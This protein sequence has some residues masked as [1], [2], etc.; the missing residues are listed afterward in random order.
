MGKYLTVLVTLCLLAFTNGSFK[1]EQ[2]RYSRVRTAYAEKEANMKN[3]LLANAIQLEQLEVYLRVFKAEQELELWAKNKGEQSYKFLK[4]YQV[5]QTSGSLGP[6]RKEGDLQI[7]E[8]F[9]HIDGFNPSSHYYLSMRL[10]YPNKSDQILG[11]KPRLGNNIFIHGDC[12]TIG[13][14]PITDEYIKELY[15]FCI[16]AKDKGQLKIPVSIYPCRLNK[17]NFA[18]LQK[19]YGEDEDKLNLWTDLKVSYQHFTQTKQLPTIT[20]LAN[21][22]HKVGLN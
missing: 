1:T 7:P 16:E 10:N 9:Y 18:K 19:K 4:T 2:R 20:F 22:R 17:E 8:G 13:C 12:V 11:Y 3:M 21:G 15:L 6:K 5:C 14:V